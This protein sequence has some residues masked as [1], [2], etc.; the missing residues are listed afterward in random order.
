MSRLGYVEYKERVQRFDFQ[1][2]DSHHFHYVIQRIEE[3]INPDEI[4]EFYPK[5]VFSNDNE[6]ELYIFSEDNMYVVS[7]GR[8]AMTMKAY[9]LGEIKEFE[10]E[11]NQDG[12]ESATLKLFIKDTYIYFDSD[13]DSNEYWT[14]TYIE[15][16]KEIVKLF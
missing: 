1:G 2:C 3:V 13:Q 8:Y 7:G 4:K 16:I 11:I 12:R 9:K 6:T 5:K 15:K 14:D 10:Y